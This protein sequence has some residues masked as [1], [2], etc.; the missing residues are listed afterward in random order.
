MEKGKIKKRNVGFLFFAVH[1]EKEEG[2]EKRR[3]E[4]DKKGV[5]QGYGRTCNLVFFDVHKKKGSKNDV[6]K[7]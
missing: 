6:E 7:G 5:K 2:G 1:E 3:R 4:S